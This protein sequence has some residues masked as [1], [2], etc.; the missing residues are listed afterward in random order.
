M[1]ADKLDTVRKL[2]AK[3]ERAATGEEAEA[4]TA[5]AVQLMARH[6]IDDALLG[7]TDPG[8]DE[9][10][11]CRVAVDDPYSAGKARLLGWVGLALGCRCVLHGVS[12]GRFTAVTVFGHASDRA[13]VEML[14][15]SLL[16]QATS[17]LVR[18][19]PLDP[20]E[21]VAAYRRSWLH[22][23]AVEV[24]RRLTAAAE[25]AAHDAEHDAAGR[26]D[27][28]PSVAL[29]LADRHDRVEQAWAEAF[30][31]LGRARR[32]VLSGSGHHD[33]VRAGARADLGRDRVG[34]PRAPALGR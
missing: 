10:G 8:H 12:G 34:P 6:G 29:V 28:G 11:V 19:R 31:D 23:F 21:S 17:Q 22:G 2:L 16:L 18:L 1:G 15:T 13:R 4:Y 33:G 9:I 20:R 32:T 26:C 24:Y 7:A 3:A 27:G 30:P 5:K 14:H 25:Q